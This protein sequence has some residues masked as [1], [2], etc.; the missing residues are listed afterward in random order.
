VLEG[1]SQMCIP[2]SL[3]ELARELRVKFETS[4][5]IVLDDL[6]DLPYLNAVLKEGMR[7][8]PQFPWIIPR[9]VPQDEG[10]RVICGTWLPGGVSFLKEDQ[11][12]EV[13]SWV[14]SFL[15]AP[16]STTKPTKT[17]RFHNITIQPP[18]HQN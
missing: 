1:L 6:Q 4:E 17:T 3:R 8:R 10:G 12:G 13:L 16:L 14:T 15:T 18:L 9:V 11:Q 2:P 7:L 5:G